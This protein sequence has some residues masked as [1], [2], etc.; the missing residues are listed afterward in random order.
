MLNEQSNG[1]VPRRGRVKTLPKGQ[2]SFE[3]VVGNVRGNP[4]LAFTRAAEILLERFQDLKA[5]MGAAVVLKLALET[6]KHALFCE[7]AQDKTRTQ[8]DAA[9]YDKFQEYLNGTTDIPVAS[10]LPPAAVAKQATFDVDSEGQD[11]Q[12][13]EQG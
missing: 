7:V 8:H 2:V 4:A 1:D 13:N 3:E 5:E 11:G 10:G 12:E 9:A 6:H